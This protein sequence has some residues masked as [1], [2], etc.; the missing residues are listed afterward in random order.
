MT[1][2]TAARATSTVTA[3]AK[4]QRAVQKEFP[5]STRCVCCTAAPCPQE[6]VV[7]PP[8]LM[9]ISEAVGSWLK[10]EWIRAAA[11]RKCRSRGPGAGGRLAAKQSN[12]GVRSLRWGEP[13]RKRLGI[14]PQCLGMAEQTARQPRSQRDLDRQRLVCA[15][16]RTAK[17]R[18]A[19]ATCTRSTEATREAFSRL[20]TH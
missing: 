7:T 10:S 15:Q 13:S 16:P 5:P 8:Y 20:K 14:S 9:I 6:G 4:P 17:A 1:A 2:L 18:R 12:G 11:L 19:S 3:R